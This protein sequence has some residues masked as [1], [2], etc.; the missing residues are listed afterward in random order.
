MTSVAA[1]SSSSWL[2]DRADARNEPGLT[3]NPKYFRAIKDLDL[4]VFKP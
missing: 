1:A 3:A 4:V 2:W